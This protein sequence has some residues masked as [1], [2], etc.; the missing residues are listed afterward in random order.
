VSNLR[1]RRGL[2]VR[3]ANGES[4]R[5]AA[6]AV[7]EGNIFEACKEIETGWSDEKSVPFSS[8]FTWH[9]ILNT[10][11]IETILVEYTYRFLF[12]SFEIDVFGLRNSQFVLQV[13]REINIDDVGSEKSDLHSC[14]HR[15]S[16][17]S[18][19]DTSFVL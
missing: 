15:L 17:C 14:D 16:R 12:R 18:T 10:V 7:L 2:T 6:A 19:W 9:R 13:K 5:P 8:H 3:F 1:N 4:Q 11:K